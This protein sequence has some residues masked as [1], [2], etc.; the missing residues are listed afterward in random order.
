MRTA[1]AN[2]YGLEEIP[3]HHPSEID[4]ENIP[5][6][7]VIQIHWAPWPKFVARLEREA[8][9][10]VVL[11]RHPL[12]VLMSWLNLALYSHLEGLCNGDVCKE[13]AIVGVLPRSDAFLRYAQGEEGKL[14]LGYSTAWW[15]RAGV[16][17]ARY[18]D[19]V[20]DPEAG[21]ARIVAE[22]G[23]EPRVP[24]TDVVATTS[25]T[26]SKPAQKAW[27]YHY[28]QGQ[29]GLWRSMLPA[30][31]ARAIAAAN[32]EPFETLGYA[33]DPDEALEGQV[34]DQN[35]LQLQLETTRENLGLERTKHRQMSEEFEIQREHLKR[36]DQ[37][38]AETSRSLAETRAHLDAL[39]KDR[40]ETSRSLAETR[41]R[42]EAFHQARAEVSRT[43]AETRVRVDALHDALGPNFLRL[44]RKTGRIAERL[45]GIN[46]FGG[47]GSQNDLESP[48]PGRAV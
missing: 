33:C 24:I 34:A 30:A 26:Q 45:R 1:L 38:L 10:V 12:D 2:L 35:W 48:R 40:A 9:R 8:I 5:G 7:C 27:H 20:A 42:I 18:E 17:R 28:W 43:L 37:D 32:R 4:W 3:V 11:A 47:R 19:L 14:L 36:F 23:E 6:R 44:A 25:I 31:E 41:A 13:C 39:F 15:D 22:V 46:P 16:I 29:P 21:F